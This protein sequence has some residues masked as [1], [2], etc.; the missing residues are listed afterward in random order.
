MK[1]IKGILQSKKF[2]E[3]LIG[4]VIIIVGKLQFDLDENAIWCI[5]GIVGI[6]IG[7]QGLADIGKEKMKEI[8]NWDEQTIVLSPDKIEQV[9][10]TKV[11]LDETLGRIRVDDDNVKKSLEKK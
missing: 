1:G 8:K 4:L 7:A 10:D 11:K 6:L 5:A 2:W 3:A 9:L